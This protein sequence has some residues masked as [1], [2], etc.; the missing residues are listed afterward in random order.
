M[1]YGTSLVMDP[2]CHWGKTHSP[3]KGQADSSIHITVLFQYPLGLG[4]GLTAVPSHRLLSE[5]GRHRGRHAHPA[6]PPK[7]PVSHSD[8]SKAS[9]RL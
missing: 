6:N 2:T 1:L 4:L 9:S 7:S 5:Q 8:G 3:L